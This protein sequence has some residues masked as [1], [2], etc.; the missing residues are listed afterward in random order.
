VQVAQDERTSAVFGMPKAAVE[1]D[2]AQL[3]RAIDEIDPRT[4]TAS[5]AGR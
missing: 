1:L 3:V 2:D 4:G 5:G